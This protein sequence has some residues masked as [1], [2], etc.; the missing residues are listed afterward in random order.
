[1]ILDNSPI[2]YA[3]H[4]EN[5]ISIEGWIND[6]ND[7]DLLNLLPLLKSLSLAI[8]VRYILG[9]KMEKSF[10]NKSTLDNNTIP[11]VYTYIY[12]YI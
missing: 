5:A 12:T 10:L 2:S 9:L 1:M 7:R 4:E 11:D 8:D 6:Q 3:L